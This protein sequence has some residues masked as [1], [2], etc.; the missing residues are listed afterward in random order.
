MLAEEVS[1]ETNSK[2]QIK[3]IFPVINRKNLEQI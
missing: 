2:I 3:K 1:R